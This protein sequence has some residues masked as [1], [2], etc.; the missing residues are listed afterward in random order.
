MLN[1]RYVDELEQRV[2][3]LEKE[4]DMYRKV[5]AADSRR[6]WDKNVRIYNAE[7]ETRRLHQR[8]ALEAVQRLNG[9]P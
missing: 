8:W 6:I 1:P 7:M 9:K 3:D 5:C 2:F 4:R